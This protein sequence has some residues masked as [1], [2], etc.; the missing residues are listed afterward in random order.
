MMNYE[1]AKVS[2]LLT[3]SG[4]GEGLRFAR[5]R[6]QHCAQ[7]V[8]KRIANIKG[9]I[10]R[11]PTFLVTLTALPLP[12]ALVGFCKSEEVTL[13]YC[14]CFLSAP[15]WLA[16]SGERRPW[17]EQQSGCEVVHTVVGAIVRYLVAKK[18]IS[19]AFDGERDNKTFSLE[20]GGLSKRCEW[21]FACAGPVL[22]QIG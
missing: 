17:E 18:C 20:V 5:D 14:S 3:K 16:L 22:V 12:A 7:A 19:C 15:G 6:C 4:V 13:A 10:K 21:E 11:E 2:K 9:G 1:G 8:Y